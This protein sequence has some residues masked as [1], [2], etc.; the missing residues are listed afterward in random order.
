[1]TRS[2]PPV[3]FPLVVALAV[4]C[5]ALGQLPPSSQGLAPTVIL[6]RPTDHSIA[7]SVE[8]GV[9]VEAYLEYGRSSGV[10]DDQTAVVASAGSAPLVFALHDLPSD[11][12]VVY[13]LRLRRPDASEFTA[14]PERSF[15]T[16][17]DRGGT[18]RFVVVADSHLG[19]ADH[20]NPTLYTRT[21][22][23]ALADAP[24]FFLDLGDTFRADHIPVVNEATVERLY[25]DQ[26]P[27]F[28]LLAASAP[29][30]LATGNHETASGWVHDGSAESS[31]VWAVR[32][33]QKHYLNP[34]P[35]GF[36]SGDTHPDPVVGLPG[37][38]YAWEWGAALFVV[39]DPY[40]YT[41]VD[42]RASGDLWD[43]TLGEEQFRWLER[44]LA[45]STAPFKFVFAH[46]VQGDGT[47]GGVE[48]AALFEW[49][50]RGRNGASEFAARR[51]G[52]EAPVHD[53]FVR[54]G[55]TAFFQG[56]DHL[57]AR[58][59]KDG[60]VYQTCPMPADASYRQTNAEF[61]RSGHVLPASG[62]LRVT[63]TP[64]T[65]TVDYLRAWLPADETEVH[66]NGEVAF[67]YTLAGKPV[68]RAP[69]RR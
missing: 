25:L 44:T 49:G 58:Q 43:W 55:V 59:E 31:A 11:A 33:R 5:P 52:W 4:A 10:Y 53:L 50:G 35:D 46:H 27:Y 26:R 20:C 29:L 51:P 7:V 17:R 65:A 47:R 14:S 61:F 37:D 54:Y 24:D 69:R 19:T 68:P 16:Q 21:L 1:M 13:R 42:P 66:R 36:Y 3:T 15:H 62:H 41:A 2:I 32:A 22:Q 56:H 6:G 39:L 28:G 18:F 40:W 57:F 63:V 30:F 8:A 38:Y 60:V 12:P 23:N 9:A 34:L 67:S 45:T 64:T 48:P